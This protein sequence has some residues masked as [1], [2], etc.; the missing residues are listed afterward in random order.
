MHLVVALYRKLTRDEI[1]EVVASLDQAVRDQKISAKTAR[2]VWG[3]V[4]AAFREAQASKNRELRV[5]TDNP[6]DNV[7]GPDRGVEKA[8]PVLFPD[9]LMRLLACEDVPL[10]RRRAYAVAA[11]LGARSNELAALTAADI[12]LAHG[13]V[14]IAKQVDRRS[15][16]VR[17]TKTKQ[18][19]AFDLEPNIIPLLQILVDER[20]QGR[21]LQ[22]PKDEE[23][24]ELVRQD[25]RTA[26]VDRAELFV[27]TDPA[28]DW[29]KFHN[30]RDTCLTWMALR[31]DDPIRVQWRGGHTDFTMT[32]RYIAAGR[33]LGARVGEVFGP[34][35]ASLLGGPPNDEPDPERRDAGDTTVENAPVQLPSDHAANDLL[36]EALALALRTKP[37]TNQPFPLAKTPESSAKMQRPQRD[38]NPCSS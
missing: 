1:E 32:Q 17:R 29:F 18:A 31:G 10:E 21:L 13:R 26:G 2:N 5:R 16:E 24:A 23:R 33:N 11:Y 19:R 3:E 34:L 15:G 12:D 7:K 36:A 6:A 28:R 22:L 30:L 27:E 20:P 38:S 37:R 4:T 35:P 25:L 9:E 14:S 8:K